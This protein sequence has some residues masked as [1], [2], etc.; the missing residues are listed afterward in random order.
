MKRI[1]TVLLSLAAALC[2]CCGLAACGGDGG[3]GGNGGEGSYGSGT[4]GNEDNTEVHEWSAW[5]VTK[6]ASCTEEGSRT[7]T[8]SE[9]GKV[10][11]ET[12]PAKDHTYNKSN[13][14]TVCGYELSPT[15]GLEYEL[16]EETEYPQGE[17]YRV[18]GMGTATDQDLV[19][20]NR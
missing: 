5:E 18:K 11:T 16:Y 3:S 15:V 2:L 14:C 12:I 8:C 4:S 7:R 6:E 1:L 19:P 13:V 20:G 17:Y 9:C 10:E